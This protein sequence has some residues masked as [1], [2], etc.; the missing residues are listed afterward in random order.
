MNGSL[1]MAAKRVPHSHRELRHPQTSNPFHDWWAAGRFQCPLCLAI[2]AADGTDIALEFTG[3][4]PY[5]IAYDYD[6]RWWQ[7]S[8]LATLPHLDHFDRAWVREGMAGALRRG[9]EKRH[10]APGAGESRG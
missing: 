3:T 1:L 2:M 9:K 4:L 7:N 8:Y 6:I 5:R 10:L